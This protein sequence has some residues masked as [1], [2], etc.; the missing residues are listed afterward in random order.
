MI[1]S[2][3]FTNQQ[4]LFFL[5]PKGEQRKFLQEMIEL[6]NN[7][8][9]FWRRNFWPKD[10]PAIP[11]RNLTSAIGQDHQDKFIQSLVQLLGE[12]KMDVPFFSPRYVAHMT[13]DVS[14]PG[15]I[16]YYAG[17]M[18]NSNN[19][20][21]EASPVTMKYELEVGRQFARLFD[22]DPEGSFGHITSGGTVANFESLFYAKGARFIPASIGLFIK[23]ED[24]PWPEF[25]PASAWELLNI[26]LKDIPEILHRFQ[27]YGENQKIDKTSIEKYSPSFLGEMAFWKE[28]QKNFK[29]DLGEPVILVPATAH[30]SWSKA[31]NL[32]GLGR[33]NCFK[34]KVNEKLS[35]SVTDLERVLAQC[36]RE[37]RTIIQSVCVLGSTEY[38]SFD[39]LDEIVSILNQWK[40]K[41]LYSPIHIDAAYGGYLKTIFEEGESFS[42][43]SSFAR[44]NH[45]ELHRIFQAV[46][47]SDSFT[48]DPHK[49]G[50]TP[51]G[52]GVFVTRHGFSKQFIAEEA[53]YCLAASEESQDNVPLGKYI[54]EGSKPGASAAA[55]YFSNKIIPLNTDGYGG[56]F[57]DLLRITG[58]F[59]RLLLES[60]KDREFSKFFE[61]VPITDP[62]SNLL[63]FFVKLKHDLRVSVT[64]VFNEEL[65]WHFFPRATDHIQ[66]FCYY[67]SK[68]S[69]KFSKLESELPSLGELEKDVEQVKLIRLVFLNRWFEQINGRGVSYMEDFI[70]E[71]KKKC[72]SLL[73]K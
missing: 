10:P 19:V 64:N 48:V 3:D 56:L 42:G 62:Q 7:D 23:G 40:K 24:L 59:H 41:G 9:I 65:I 46:R 53:D 43:L 69:L 55:V 13:G 39:P 1:K 44:E 33:G 71:L 38:G 14:L 50:H 63:C 26:E 51:Y 4:D 21:A 2:K 67:V 29:E 61:F 16:G 35:M 52:S 34:V 22:Y 70:Y 49:L 11:Y 5:G 73:R 68:T 58:E 18:Y 30:Y 57:L 37:R 17:L 45:P 60:N 72:F 47:D 36:E 25:L 8:V 20:S 66:E 31:S 6:I 27:V 12:L 54:L 32:F 15:L 28:L